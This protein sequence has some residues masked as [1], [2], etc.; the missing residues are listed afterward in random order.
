MVK[1]LLRKLENPSLIPRTFTKIWAWWHGFVI[2]HWGARD[3]RILGVHWLNSSG[4]LQANYRD[5]TWVLILGRQ[6]TLPTEPHHQPRGSSLSHFTFS[7]KSILWGHSPYL[8]QHNHFTVSLVLNA[9][10]VCFSFAN[11]GGDCHH[12]RAHSSATAELT[13]EGYLCCAT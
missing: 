3:M 12:S 11:S 6:S 1:Y 7:M 5:G 10:L 4:G 9:C 13:D 2:L 8:L